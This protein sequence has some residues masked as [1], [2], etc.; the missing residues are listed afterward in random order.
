MYGN[1]GQGIDEEQ[2][3]VKG[4][5]LLPTPSPLFPYVE[6][7]KGR[8]STYHPVATHACGRS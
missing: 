4:E 1:N 7:L 2:Q 8:S 3:G 5:V 6:P